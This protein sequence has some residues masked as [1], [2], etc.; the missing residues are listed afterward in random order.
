MSMRLALKA[1]LAQEAVDEKTK[2]AAARKAK[3]DAKA[4]AKEQAAADARARLAEEAASS[5][6]AEA[7]EEATWDEATR[8]VRRR[9]GARLGEV[10]ATAEIAD[11]K[12]KSLRKQLEGELG[13]ELSGEEHKAWFKAKVTALV[14]AKTAAADLAAGRKPGDLADDEEDPRHPVLSDEMAAVVGV[15]R[16]NHFRLVKLLWKYIKK[17]DLQNPANKNEI[18]CDDALKA[19]FKKDKVTS[20]GMSKLLSAHYFK[21]DAPAPKKRKSARDDGD[22]GAGDGADA[23]P[24]PKKPKKK[25]AAASSAEYKGSREMA[26]FCGVRAPRVRAPPR[27][28][29]DRRFFAGRDEQPVHD[30]EDRLGPHQGARAPEGGR[31]AH[32]HLRRDAQGPLPG[33]RVQPVPDGQAHRHALLLAAP[34]KPGS[35]ER[36]RN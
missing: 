28:T 18:V 21:D 8:D 11:L 10:L 7:A 33:R 15:G 22:D 19:V 17:H 30:H 6:A 5:A 14:E 16:A 20:F 23:A 36:P 31:Q 34:E 26:D 24:A 12:L 2:Q 4:A 13:V 9:V 35:S 32:D 25:P 29:P 1:S 27:E 3:K